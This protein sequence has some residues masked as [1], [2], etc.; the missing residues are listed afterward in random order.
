MLSEGQ[1]Q[2]AEQEKLDD[3]FKEFDKNGDGKLQPEEI[4]EAMKSFGNPGNVGQAQFM[5]EYDKDGNVAYFLKLD[6][7]L[8]I[9]L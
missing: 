6:R 9:P 3:M 2:Q 8:L 5:K 7:R 4:A 1:L